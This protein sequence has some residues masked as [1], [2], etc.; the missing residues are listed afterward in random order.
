[1]QGGRGFPRWWRVSASPGFDSLS[2]G[3]GH[4]QILS[5]PSTTQPES[6]AALCEDIDLRIRSTQSHSLDHVIVL[7]AAGMSP[8]L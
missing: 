1:M 8:L 2:S 4:D 5:S 6:V 7:Q 3:Q